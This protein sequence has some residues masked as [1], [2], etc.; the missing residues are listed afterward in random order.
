M[1]YEPY[2]NNAMDYFRSYFS[3]KSVDKDTITS[4]LNTSDTSN[5]YQQFSS[6]Q[7]QSHQQSAPL[8]AKAPPVISNVNGG[9]YT[10]GL[11]YYSKVEGISPPGKMASSATGANKKV[12]LVGDPQVG[13]T[14]IACTLPKGCPIM[15]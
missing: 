4:S 14:A 3:P 7:Q 15:C 10:P 11:N 9:S 6:S 1:K 12:I 13:K 8:Q 2:L 5:Y